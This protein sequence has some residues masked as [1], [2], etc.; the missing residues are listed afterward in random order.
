MLVQHLL[1]KMTHIQHAEVWSIILGQS[2]KKRIFFIFYFAYNLIKPVSSKVLPSTLDT[3]LPTFFQIWN[4]SWNV[5]CEMEQRSLTNFLLWNLPSEIGELLVRISTSRTRKSLQGQ[6]W[7]V[8]SP[9][10]KVISCF[11]KNWRISSASATKRGTNFV[12]TWCTWVWLVKIRWHY[13]LRIPTSLATSRTV[14]RWFWWIIASTFST[15]SL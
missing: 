7:R 6:I 2:I 4:T 9:G 13:L 3:L 10:D 15:W 14:R 1:L 11:V 12:A 8:G 5:F